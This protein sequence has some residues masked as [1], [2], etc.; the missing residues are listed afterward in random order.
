MSWRDVLARAATS[1]GAPTAAPAL[2]QFV[3]LFERWNQRINLSAARSLDDIAQHVVDSLALLPHL[4]EAA[5]LVD[6]GSGGGFPLIVLGACR[7]TISLRGVEPIHKKTAFL[8]T[9]VR[10]LRLANVEIVTRRVDP[11]LDRGFDVATSRATFAL[12]EW[13]ALGQQLVRGGGRVLGMEAREQV[14]LGPNDE[15]HPYAAGDRQRAV[16]V[17]RV[18]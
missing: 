10:E 1:V 14:A 12:D 15:R 17:R 5:S 2:V 3:E 16:I 8:S 11:E 7:P 6:V 4:G 18:P 13:L 9:A